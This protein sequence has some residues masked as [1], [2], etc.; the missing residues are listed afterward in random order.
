MVI[1]S[2]SLGPRAEDSNHSGTAGQ[3]D[4]HRHGGQQHGRGGGGG[5]GV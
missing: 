1:L 3:H 4:G 5:E 2:S